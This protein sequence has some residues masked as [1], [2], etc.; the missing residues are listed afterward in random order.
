VRVFSTKQGNLGLWY[1]K[2]E[3]L[4]FFIFHPSDLKVFAAE[5]LLANKKA[6]GFFCHAEPIESFE[7]SSALREGIH[8]QALPQDFPDELLVVSERPAAT[9]DVASCS[10][11]L[12]N[13]RQHTVS[14]YPQRWFTGDRFDLGYQ[15]ITRVCRDPES[16][17]IIGDGVRIGS[18]LLDASNCNLDRWL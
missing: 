6:E 8:Q 14:V 3:R 1:P 10:I 12:L 16:N 13:T 5:E 11:F 18:F 4:K 2:N 9:S 7:L 17:R 15:W